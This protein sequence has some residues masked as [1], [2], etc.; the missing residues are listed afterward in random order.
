M[1]VLKHFVT[2]SY[3][4]RL[5]IVQNHF[6]SDFLRHFVPKYILKNVQNNSAY[7]DLI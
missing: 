2:E 1:E 5:D 4:E 6:L 7:N 3:T